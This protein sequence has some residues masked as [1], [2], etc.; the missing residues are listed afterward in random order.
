MDRLER[1]NA[2]SN[3]CEMNAAIIHAQAERALIELGLNSDSVTRIMA[4]AAKLSTKDVDAAMRSEGD[5]V[6]WSR[7]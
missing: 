3:N 2:A 5:R 7:E 1:I 6:C 4:G